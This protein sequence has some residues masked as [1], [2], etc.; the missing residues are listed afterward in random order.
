MG[1]RL[2]PVTPCHLYAE[3]GAVCMVTKLALNSRLEI[4]KMAVL[5]CCTV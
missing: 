2:D 5:G 1:R 3:Y 4:L